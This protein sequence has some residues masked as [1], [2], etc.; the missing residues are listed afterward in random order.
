M[1]CILILDSCT[2]PSIS[3]YSI[4]NIYLYCILILDSSSY[5]SIR[6]IF[7]IINTCTVYSILILDSSTYPSIRWDYFPKFW[8]F[9]R[10]NLLVLYFRKYSIPALLPI[11]YN[12]RC[13]CWVQTRIP[14][15]EC[16][17]T[18]C[19]SDRII[20]NDWCRCWVQTRIPEIECLITF[21]KS[22]R[23]FSHLW[24]KIEHISNSVI[25]FLLQS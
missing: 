11:I 5:L 4:Y 25:Q 1:Y 2:Y 16:L 15:I 7:Y 24:F 12:D 18:F 9:P 10:L 17:I 3:L 22:D 23:M 19:K 13:R 20:Y 21:C 8:T 14:E 6:F